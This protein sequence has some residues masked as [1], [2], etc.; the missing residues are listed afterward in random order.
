MTALQD[1]S[2]THVHVET[3]TPCPEQSGAD[4]NRVYLRDEYQYDKVLCSTDSKLNWVV[5]TNTINLPD[6][7]RR[8]DV[9]SSTQATKQR[10]MANL[11][12]D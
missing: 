2:C 1:S 6:K 8:S 9:Y 5:G 11:A 7:A 10:S 12:G 4:R 3:L